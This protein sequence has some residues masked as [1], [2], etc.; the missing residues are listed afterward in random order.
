MF[1]LGCMILVFCSNLY[2]LFGWGNVGGHT[3]ASAATCFFWGATFLEIRLFIRNR[4]SNTYDFPRSTSF[5]EG[6][7]EDPIWV[8]GGTR[9]SGFT[10]HPVRPVNSVKKQSEK[11]LFF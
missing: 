9:P 2:V 10:I 6:S 7:N 3:L 5:G 4:T 1:R 8:R 11:I